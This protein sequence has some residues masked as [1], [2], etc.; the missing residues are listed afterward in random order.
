MRQ[1]DEEQE[2]LQPDVSLGE[3]LPGW[4][5]PPPDRRAAAVNIV[6]RNAVAIFGVLFLGWSGAEI[7]VLYFLDTLAALWGIFTAVTYGL[8]VSKRQSGFDRLYWWATALALGAFLSA[9]LA[10]PLGMPVLFVAAANSWR[11]ADALAAEGFRLALVGVVVVGLAGAL[12]RSLQAAQ[13]EA[14]MRSLRWEFTLVF[15]R[16]FVVIAVAYTVAFVVPRASA[17]IMILAYAG[18]SVFTELYPER[19]VAL[20]PD[21]GNKS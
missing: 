11:P 14:G 17:V 5:F 12:L 8:Y 15:G 6:V 2:Q 21:R 18:A 13:G 19:F 7:V 20:F 9:F 1:P 10:I 16:W 3:G 4:P